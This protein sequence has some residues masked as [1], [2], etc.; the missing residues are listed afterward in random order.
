MSARD[1][2][3]DSS[4][5]E[6]SSFSDGGQTSTGIWN[7]DRGGGRRGIDTQ[8]S[9]GGET[10]PYNSDEDP[11]ENQEHAEAY[12]MAFEEALCGIEEGG[13]G[14]PKYQGNAE[15]KRGGNEGGQGTSAAGQAQQNDATSRR[16][17]RYEGGMWAKREK[18]GVEEEMRNLDT[19]TRQRGQ[20]E[21]RG[22]KDG[23]FK[24]EWGLARLKGDDAGSLLW[25]ERRERLSTPP[26]RRCTAGSFG[27]NGVNEVRILF[28]MVG[29]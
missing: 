5:A 16:E 19:L 21:I 22:N 8:G 27:R 25:R 7:A 18:G 13:N 3:F 26:Q 4:A 24:T 11:Y 1:G 23:K 12:A 9:E 29:I 2:R 17:E 10:P 15:A 6:K 28:R 20:E 14:T